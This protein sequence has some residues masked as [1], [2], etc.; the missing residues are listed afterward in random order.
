MIRSGDSAAIH[1]AI[2]DAIERFAER[3]ATQFEQSGGGSTVHDAQL[4]EVAACVRE[5]G[6]SS[7]TLRR[8]ARL[9]TERAKDN[10]P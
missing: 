3:V 7:R 5:A 1:A 2:S 6:K 9:A 10:I 8:E 4:R